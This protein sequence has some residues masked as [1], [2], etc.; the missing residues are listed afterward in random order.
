M[1]EELRPCPF[2]GGEVEL[3]YYH[4]STDG[5][6][7]RYANIKCCCGVRMFLDEKE[8]KR[9]MEK[10]DYKGGYF[11]INKKFWYGMHNMLIEK[12]NRRVAD[13]R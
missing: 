13:E 2:C 7:D 5:K 4:E 12:W 10:F 6:Q 1:S 9:A 3:I 8:L 11:S